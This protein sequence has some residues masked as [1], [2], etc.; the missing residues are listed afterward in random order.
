M[1]YSQFNISNIE[2]LF[3]I[4][5]IETESLFSDIQPAQVSERLLDILKYNIHLALANNTEKARSEMIIAPMLIELKRLFPNKISLFSGLEFNIDEERGLA[6]YCDFII[7]KTAEQLFVKSPVIMLVEAKNESIKNGI[8][9]CIAEMIAAQIFNQQQNTSTE[10]IY[11][12]VTTGTSWKFLKLMSNQ[13]KID[14][15]EYYIS[16]LEKIW[17]ILKTIV[18][19]C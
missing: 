2:N 14:L 16:E 4:E 13:V 5:L 19:E 1:S 17:G 3:H 10:I 12:I 6:G 9:Q 7:S 15:M 11:G 8:A 18:V